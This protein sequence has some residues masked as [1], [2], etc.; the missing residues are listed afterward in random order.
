MT[1]SYLG[2]GN[3]TIDWG[4]FTDPAAVWRI[5]YSETDGG[6]WTFADEF[7]AE[8]RTANIGTGVAADHWFR[9]EAQ[10]SCGNVVDALEGGPF[11]S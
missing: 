9:I 2:G 6:P 1:G 4:A 8:D 7:P 5:Y 10:D 3:F 11:G